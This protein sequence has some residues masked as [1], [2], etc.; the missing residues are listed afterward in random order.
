LSEHPDKIPTAAIDE[1]NVFGI[2][3]MSKNKK[4]FIRFT[5]IS[6]YIN[7]KPY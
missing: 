1:I 6:M 4:F 7:S 3:E 2:K 5:K